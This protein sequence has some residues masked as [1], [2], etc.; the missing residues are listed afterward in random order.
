MKEQLRY[1]IC[2]NCIMDTSDPHIKFDNLGLCT[3]CHNFK[4]NILGQ[5]DLGIS[6]NSLLLSLSDKIKRSNST[7]NDFMKHMVFL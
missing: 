6:T 5:W 2:S 4:V 1:S 7:N 3:H